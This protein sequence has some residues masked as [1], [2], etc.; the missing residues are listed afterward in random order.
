MGVKTD[1]VDDGDDEDLMVLDAPDGD[2]D[3]E[4]GETPGAE[5]GGDEGPA[6]EAEAEADE[7]VVTIGDAPVEQEE[8]EGRAPEWVR[9][10][11]KTNR[12][13]V[14]KLRERD[15]EFDRLKGV[16]AAPATVTLGPKP[17]LEGADFDGDK[18]AEQLEA[19]HARKR[20]ADE[21]AA[22]VQRQE[23]EA[24]AAWQVK[25]TAYGAAKAALKVRDYEDAEAVAQET[26]SVV[27]QGIIL[28]GAKNPA[29]LVYALG[30]S[31]AKAKELAAITDPVKFAFAAAEVETQLKT[32]P[33]K[34]A[35]PPEQRLRSSA[36]GASATMGT[37][38]KLE[39]L[40]EAGLKSGDMNEYLA[41]KRKL[42]AK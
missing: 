14:R 24:R 10:L 2:T 27:Q 28:N 1:P 22:A 33:R 13:L 39:A 35:P 41:A 32:T 18:F 16:A 17:T 5:D 6:V 8:P 19:W 29:L 11:R 21:Q 30:K 3:A 4:P 38:R 20:Q 12:E 7:V 23:D 15:A 26:L 36:A 25:L 42:A 9:D 34:S 40:R 37:N 31:P